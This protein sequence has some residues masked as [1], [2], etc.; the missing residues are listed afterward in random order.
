MH[1]SYRFT[2][3]KHKDFFSFSRNTFQVRDELSHIVYGSAMPKGLIE[4]RC[5][6]EVPILIQVTELEEQEVTGYFSIFGLEDQPLVR[7]LS[8][9]FYFNILNSL[10]KLY[11]F[12]FQIHF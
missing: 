1:H 9:C 11:L 5:S 6:V 2:T 12:K 8:L 7:R 10:I 4:P 3:N